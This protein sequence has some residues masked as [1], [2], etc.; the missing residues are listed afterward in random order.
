M[1]HFR[2]YLRAFELADFETTL[3]WHTDE[4]IMA[5]VVGP[6]YFVGREYE[7]KWVEEAIFGTDSLKF[8][9]CVEENQK[10]IGLVSLSDVNWINRSAQAGWMIGDKGS[11]GMGFATE[12]V[13]QL[14]DFGFHERGLHRI[15]CSILESNSA[16][17]R[18]AAKCGYQEEGLLRDVVF[19]RGKF[20]NLVVLSVLNHEFAGIWKRYNG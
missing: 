18:V 13:L 20:H 8:G 3:Q 11:W 14:L 6:K 10:L 1:R 4:I 17:R 9:V 12:A 19:K 2:T 7:R 16:S 5:S 15:S